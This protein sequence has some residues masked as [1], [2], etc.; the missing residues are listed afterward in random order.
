[1]PQYTWCSVEYVDDGFQTQGFIKDFD[2]AEEDPDKDDQIFFYGVS[3]EELLEACETGAVF[4]N[5]WRVTEVGETVD[6]LD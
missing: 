3:R 2:S 4:E 6:T 1:M 5:E